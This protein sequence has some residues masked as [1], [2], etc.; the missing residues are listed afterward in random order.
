MTNIDAPLL[1]TMINNDN[2][3]D[4]RLW[5]LASLGINIDSVIVRRQKRRRRWKKRKNKKK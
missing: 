3:N 5:Q 4:H 2:C 1:P